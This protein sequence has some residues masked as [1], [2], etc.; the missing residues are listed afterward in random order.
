MHDEF[1]F[2]L[3]ISS[4]HEDICAVSKQIYNHKTSLWTNAMR[5]LPPT[6]VWP[7]KSTDRVTESQ[8]QVRRRMQREQMKK[9]AA[10]SSQRE[11]Y[12]RNWNKKDDF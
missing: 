2:S 6:S 5:V 7:P 11:L 8:R 9:V 3:S 10:N 12:V 4:M 1:F